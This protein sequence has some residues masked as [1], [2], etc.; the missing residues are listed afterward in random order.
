MY[1][2]EISCSPE[3][4]DELSAE[5]WEAGTIGI[6]E[7]EPAD[8]SVRLIAGF[9]SAE[10]QKLLTRFARHAPHWRQEPAIDWLKQSEQSW[11]GRLVGKTFFL[12]PPWCR[13]ETP[14]GRTRLIHNPGLACGTGEHP[15]TQMA[16][17]ALEDTVQPFSRV[18]DIG[19]GSGIL[20]IAAL[21]LGAKAVIGVDIDELAVTVAADN[22]RLNRL[23]P[24]LAVGSADRIRLDWADILV[25]NISGTVLLSIWDDIIGAARP[26]GTLILTGFSA[27]ES[28]AFEELL[29][30][31]T[32]LSSGKWRCIVGAR[33]SRT[34]GSSLKHGGRARRPE[35]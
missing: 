2:L 32:V 7:L 34:P 10:S 27:G 31:P 26:G 8:G 15:C 21:Q 4:A 22:F 3:E 13:E 29:D 14:A 5:L 35:L 16:I 24:R 1:S 6:R 18:A 33:G 25:A 28:H 30:Y 19:T 17:E 12:C 23:E 11:P 9:E 20:S